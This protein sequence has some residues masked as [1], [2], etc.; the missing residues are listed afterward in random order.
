MRKNFPK[1]EYTRGDIVTFTFEHEQV[2]GEIYIVDR[3]GTFEQNEEPSYDILVENSPH[4]DGGC[5]LYKHIRQSKI[6]EKIS[7]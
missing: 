4:C 3:Y 7:K 5:C 6:V 1:A 2:T